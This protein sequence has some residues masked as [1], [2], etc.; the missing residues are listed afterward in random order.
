MFYG[1]LADGVVAIHVTYVSFVL[2]G[3]AAIVLGALLGWQWIRNLWFRLTHFAAIAY[4]AWEALWGIACPL[5]VWEYDLRRLA[6][7]E[8]GE[9]TFIGR[10]L[11]EILFYDLEPWVFT[12][13]Y[14]AFALLVLATLVAAPPRWRREPIR[15]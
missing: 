1:F 6:G 5:T 11:H 10:W 2:F 12:C 3:Q 9:G 13:A 15:A 14:V 8:A 4:V 7:Q